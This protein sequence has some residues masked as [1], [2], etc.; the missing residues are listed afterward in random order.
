MVI[1][2]LLDTNV[3]SELLRPV[4]EQR[5]LAYIRSHKTA[6]ASVIS[7][8]ELEYGAARLP[9]GQR[10][11]GYLAAI[12]RIM[13]THAIIPVYTRTA[14]LAGFLRA[15][16]QSQGRTMEIADALIA[17]TAIENGLCLATRNT[18]DFTGIDILLHNPWSP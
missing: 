6:F 1:P 14:S 7:I 11:S 4:P 18:R 9:D 15:K 13:T 16:Q 3:L 10:K 5:V 8:H 12:Q 2:V 17:A